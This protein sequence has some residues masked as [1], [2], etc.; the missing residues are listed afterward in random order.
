LD[1][2]G[3]AYV[4]GISFAGPDPI[5]EEDYLTIKYNP[6]GVQQW[7]ARYNEPVSEPDRATAIAVDKAGNSFVTGYS[8]GVG[9]DIATVKY[10]ASETHNGWRDMMDLHIP[11]ILPIPSH[12]TMPETFM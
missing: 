5:G 1:Q 11:V 12:W 4:T 2:T 3:N 9:L 8:Q 6:A 10:N 7:T